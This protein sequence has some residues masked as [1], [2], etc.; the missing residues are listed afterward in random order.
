MRRVFSC[1]SFRLELAKDLSGGNNLFLS[2]YGNSSSSHY[3][4]AQ[5]KSLK[6]SLYQAS[7][8]VRTLEKKNVM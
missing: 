1:P 7:R 4:K 8:F 2:L 3:T 6:N 5:I